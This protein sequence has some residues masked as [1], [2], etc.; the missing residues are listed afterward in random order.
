MLIFENVV[1]YLCKFPFATHDVYGWLL[2]VRRHEK[3]LYAGDYNV[4]L[5]LEWTLNVRLEKI[6]KLRC[7][8][9]YWVRYGPYKLVSGS[10]N[11]IHLAIH[12]I[13][14]LS[15]NS[16]VWIQ[17]G[18]NHNKCNMDKYDYFWR[19][20]PDQIRVTV[21]LAV[22]KTVT[23]WSEHKYQLNRK[24]LLQRAACLKQRAKWLLTML[25]TVNPSSY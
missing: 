15:F 17:P 25:D 3:D 4:L 18:K 13:V 6:R 20:I 16:W 10:E 22:F 8:Y 12:N 21:M 9:L 19:K 24:N 11:F 5:C 23:A 14:S 2:A 7:T 1:E